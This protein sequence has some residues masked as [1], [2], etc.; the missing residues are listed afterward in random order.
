ML[1]QKNLQTSQNV[2]RL[3]D[4]PHK[5]FFPMKPMPTPS[6]IIKFLQSSSLT[7]QSNKLDY[8]VKKPTFEE[9]FS[10][11]NNTNLKNE[12]IINQEEAKEETNSEE[13]VEKF[14]ESEKASIVKIH[15]ENTNLEN[16]NRNSFEDNEIQDIHQLL[17]EKQSIPFRNTKKSITRGL[18]KMVSFDGEGNLITSHRIH[19][20]LTPFLMNKF[21]KFP[22]EY[23]ESKIKKRLFTGEEDD[24]N[25]INADIAKGFKEI[26]RRNVEEMNKENILK[27]K[28]K[29]KT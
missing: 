11:N 17:L 9:F 21:K 29:K 20:K 28:S 6:E 7:K 2:I 4:T 19:R 10:N 22:T 13:N 25:T 14:K 1:N 27:E 26:C 24:E 12:V 16:L 18:K 23:E 5:V 8:N 3:N 15:F